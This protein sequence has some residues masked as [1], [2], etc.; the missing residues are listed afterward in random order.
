MCL[1]YTFINYYFTLLKYLQNI[2]ADN[3]SVIINLI[4]II[5]VFSLYIL[6]SV[7]V[8]CS[9]VDTH[10]NMIYVC[11]KMKSYDR[12]QS[13]LSVWS[14]SCR[15]CPSNLLISFIDICLSEWS[16]VYVIEDASL[17]L[18]TVTW[19]RTWITVTTVDTNLEL[20]PMTR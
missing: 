16:H 13:Q 6:Q 2:Q 12:S 3:Y 19:P 17:Q 7:Y 20:T 14:V 18:S 1:Y 9:D 15:D 8:D 10:D 4:T 5:F 11:N